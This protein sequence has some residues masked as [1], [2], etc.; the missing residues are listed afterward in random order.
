MTTV[1]K[2]IFKKE[3][4]YYS[5]LDDLF[6]KIASEVND[7]YISVKHGASTRFFIVISGEPYSAAVVDASGRKL[8]HIQDFF[9]F[10]EK[11][12]KF[13]IEAFSADKKLLLC[14]LVGFAYKPSQS[15]TTDVVD[16]DDA[17]K[18][19][20][21]A[22]TDLIMILQPGPNTKRGVGFA[23][24]VKGDPAFVFLPKE[25]ADGSPLHK[26]LDY[27]YTL[28]EGE[29]LSINIYVNTKV[30]PASDA[31]PFPVGGITKQYSSVDIGTPYI[32][33]FENG[34]SIGMYDVNGEVTIGRDSTNIIRL[35]EAGV[36]REHAVIKKVGDK[37]IVED[38]KSANGT[39]FKNIKIEKKELTHGDEI[40]IR[41]Y[42]LKL[43]IP[44]QTGKPDAAD[45]GEDLAKRVV[46][47]D[48]KPVI[49]QAD[50]DTIRTATLTMSDGTKHVL[51]SITS[52][53]RDEDCDIV[54]DGITFAKRHATLVKGKNIYKI[55]KKGGMA[56]VKVNGDKVEEATLKNGDI[57]E[58]GGYS[59]TFNL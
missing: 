27:C 9:N 23:I 41:E 39:S 21:K 1:A 12:D 29:T 57:I 22:G 6:S 20:K 32:E 11:L 10:C 38:L 24:F 47:K 7:C 45:E 37:V 4:F 15:F 26:L 44:S 14:M 46:Y 18:K 13:N 30:T 48:G 56:A 3:G 51:T 8:T 34:K 43:V 54:L 5:E 35:P 16:V 25:T 33:L 58:I 36:S 2:S 28:T 42:T 17:L 49:A 31:G 40:V 59:M 50:D 55:I 52:F 19:I 53:G